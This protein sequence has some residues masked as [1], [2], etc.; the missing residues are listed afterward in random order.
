MAEKLI[1]NPLL[2]KGFQYHY[3]GTDVEAFL[4]QTINLT[5]Y[6]TIAVAASDTGAVTPIA[7]TTIDPNHFGAIGSAIISETSG[8]F[9][10]NVTPKN[11][12]GEFITATISVGGTVNFSDVMNGDFAIFYGIDITYRNFI[13]LDASVKIRI[14]DSTLKVDNSDN[15]YEQIILIS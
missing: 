11:I 15:C 9:P 10:T 6:E 2:K 12:D 8:G 14:V 5:I 4:E 7:N 13:T 3:D 1:Y